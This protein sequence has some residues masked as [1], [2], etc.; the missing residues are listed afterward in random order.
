MKDYSYKID[1]DKNFTQILEFIDLC[2]LYVLQDEVHTSSIIDT[3]DQNEFIKMGIGS[4]HS[5]SKVHFDEG[6]TISPENSIENKNIR[7]TSLKKAQF[8]TKTI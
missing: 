4:K 2:N 1:S 6:I 5:I 8:Q 3:L 7:T